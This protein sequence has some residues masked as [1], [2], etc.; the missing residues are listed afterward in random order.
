MDFIGLDWLQLAARWIH[1]IVGIAWIGSSFYFVWQD[2]SLE[3]AP[4]DAE[5]ARLA[6]QV[7]MV[8]GGGFYHVRKFKVAPARLPP[9]LHWFKWEAYSTW[10]SGMSL[11]ILVYWMGA[12]TYLLP[13][14]SALAPWQGVAAAAAFLTLAW[15]VYDLLCRSP[16][17]KAEGWLALAVLLLLVGL[18]YAAA[19]VFAGRAAY[20][21]VGAALGTLMVANVFLVIIPNQ[22]K[23][24]AA[25]LRGEV[26][27]PVWGQRGKQRSVHNTYFT[28][29]VLFLMISNHFPAAFA[30]RY[31][32]L[33]LVA[34]ALVGAAV[35]RVFVLRHAGRH[36]PWMLPAAALAFALLAVAVNW[37][38]VSAQP[39][40]AIGDSDYPASPFPVVQA[41]IQARCV[42][43]HSAHPS[44]AGFEVAPQGVVFDTAADIVAKTPLIQVQAVVSK[45][46]PLGNLTAMS[47][48]E[49][50][51]L[52]RWIA[53][54]AKH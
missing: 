33:I 8:H 13:A 17:G 48:E 23:M 22:R 27:D 42:G 50:I 1:L 40:A 38:R 11:L 30:H 32:W 47:E 7:W 24:V 9:H 15:L 46:M 4:D 26:P 29:P 34:V 6:G 39:A 5:A 51:I 36:R 31:N 16:L 53:D 18:S 2:N 10:I 20:I 43:C 44:I 12:S 21:H 49:R 19:Q 52:G 37:D 3:P 14:D 54:G 28:L 41:I 25:M 35:R 45:A